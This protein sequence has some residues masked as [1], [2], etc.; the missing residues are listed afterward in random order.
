MFVTVFPDASVY[1]KFTLTRAFQLQNRGNV[2]EL[3]LL[4]LRLALGPRLLHSK[5]TQI[6]ILNIHK[7]QNGDIFYLLP[8]LTFFVFL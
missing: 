4:P 1:G 7:N 5:Q 2:S 6:Q 3:G 8:T